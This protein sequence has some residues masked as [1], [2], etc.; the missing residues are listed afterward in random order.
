MNKR[1]IIILLNVL[2]F[3]NDMIWKLLKILINL[4]EELFF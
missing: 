1:E 2:D 4:N 3:D